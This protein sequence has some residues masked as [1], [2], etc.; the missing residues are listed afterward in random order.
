MFAKSNTRKNS[1]ILLS[2]IV[3]AGFMI[4]Y[5]HDNGGYDAA[6]AQS[7]NVLPKIAG[8]KARNIILILT[9][10]HRWDA[11]GFAGHPF[12]ETPHMDA[13]ARGGAHMR[14][15]FV[16]TSLC[17]PSRASILT[18]QYTHRHRVVDN[19]NPVP[20]GLTFFP[21][22]LQQA[23]Y[24]TAFVG[25][26]HMGSDSDAPQPGFNQWVSFKGQGTYWPN[27][28][29]LNVNGKQV[30]Q[31]GYITDELTD[32]AVDWLN[33]RNGGKPFMLYLSHKAVHTDMLPD[34]EGRGK[35]LLPGDTDRMGFPGAP[36]HA[37]RYKNKTFTPPPTM[38]LTARNYAD[39]PMWVQNRRNSR[40]GVELPMGHRTPISVL[41]RQY[42]EALLAVDDS[43]GRVLAALRQ[44]GMLDSTMIV[45]MGDNGYAWGEHGMVDK[46]AAYEESM[47]IPMI[48]HC[49]EL[50]KGGT[51]VPQMVANIDIA[52]T[53]LEAAGLEHPRSMDG[54]SFL[55]L[56]RGQSI[57]WR[58][59][60]LYEYYWEW[61]FPMTPTIH[62]LRGERYKYIRQYGVWDIDE[63]YDLQNDPHEITNLIRSEAHQQI[64]REM[65][66]QLF[67]T[68]EETQGMYIPL[69]ADRGGQGSQRY[70][71]GSR[72]APFPAWMLK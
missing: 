39:K 68:L 61:N 36:R 63:L 29:G 20:P 56:A 48:A 26:W 51:V 37:G 5:R 17:S 71:R 2:I 65:K 16:N 53:L 47:R 23:G 50:I 52:P 19:N 10:D 21:Q 60:F 44:K 22:Y 49:P 45:Y 35:L 7:G 67:R 41:Y 13:L 12:V 11:M 3:I 69:F 18:G 66:E 38:A 24:E 55:P 46:R 15:A 72:G 64:I 40:H 9:D 4:M 57:A 8:A 1:L 34:R 62:A 28:N 43:V 32:Y 70:A 59:R 30:G 6:L 42:M 27:P 54:R 14:N 58:D 25:K 33:A 31:K